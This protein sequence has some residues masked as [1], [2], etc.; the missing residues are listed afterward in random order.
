MHCN[1]CGSEEFVDVNGR[2]QV[3]CARCGS[4]E[5]TRV[6]KMI[7]DRELRI[8]PGMA[9]FHIAPEAGLSDFFRSL[10]EV[11]YRAVDLRPEL[12]RHCRVEQMNLVDEAENLPSGAYDLVIHSHV[13]EHIPSNVSA[14][15]M[16][17]H[18]ALKDDGV[19]VFSIPIYSGRFEECFAEIGPEERRRRFH[20]EDHVRR[21]GRDDLQLTLGKL[22]SIPDEY[23]L[24]QRYPGVDFA[25]FNIPAEATRGY[26]SHSV[27]CLRKGDSRLHRHP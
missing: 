20:Q 3:K 4:V 21:F 19:H 27:F 16:H 18:R 9:I 10:A 17:L 5:R 6:I 1:L 8:R 13:M 15:L 24:A 12:Y 25:H 11:N 7:L 22:F 26:S 23:D 2:P 14:V